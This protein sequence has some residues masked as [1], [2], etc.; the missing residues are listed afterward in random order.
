MNDGM[1]RGGEIFHLIIRIKNK[2]NNNINNNNNLV[3]IN[4]PYYSRTKKTDILSFQMEMMT[5]LTM[6]SQY[7]RS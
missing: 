2:N 5:V 7:Q 4:I 1:K 3:L 6:Y